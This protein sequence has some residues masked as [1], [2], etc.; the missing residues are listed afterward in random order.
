MKTVVIIFI[1]LM[2][3]LMAFQES[4]QILYPYLVGNDSL[5]YRDS[6]GNRQGIW[7]GMTHN[8][9]NCTDLTHF[10][11]AY[12]YDDQEL[13]NYT[14]TDDNNACYEVMHGRSVNITHPVNDSVSFYYYYPGIPEVL[15]WSMNNDPANLDTL[16]A[17]I[18]LS[19][20]FDVARFLMENISKD[21]LEP[22]TYKE[23]ILHGNYLLWDFKNYQVLDTLKY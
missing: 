13:L 5:N 20:E 12:F 6:L 22:F 11:Y 4:P 7:F 19:Q 18:L 1:G 10:S 3:G 21:Y 9:G 23:E 8:I 2:G 14:F 15:Y 16:N 17:S